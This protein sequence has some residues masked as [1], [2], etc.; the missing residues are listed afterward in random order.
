V[1][2]RPVLFCTHRPAPPLD[3]FAP[4]YHGPGDG[5][6]ERLPGAVLCGTWP[7]FDPASDELT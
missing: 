4:C 1:S 6:V 5:H 3:R 2:Y 7:F